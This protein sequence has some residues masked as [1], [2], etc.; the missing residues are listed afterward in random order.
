MKPPPSSLQSKMVG[1]KEG[2]G[3][4]GRNRK[5][6]KGVWTGEMEV[7]KEKENRIGGR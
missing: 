4:D 3:G 2:E 6:R 7:R 1:R 5:K